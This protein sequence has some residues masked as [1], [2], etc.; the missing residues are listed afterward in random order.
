MYSDELATFIFGCHSAA[1]RI[2][3]EAGVHAIVQDVKESSRLKILES[4]LAAAGSGRMERLP[5]R[6]L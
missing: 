6:G 4:H 3:D 5:R 1:M 2:L